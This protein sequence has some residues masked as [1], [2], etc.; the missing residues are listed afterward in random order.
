MPHVQN[1]G[2]ERYY[3]TNFEK[4]RGGGDSYLLE[5]FEKRRRGGI[6]TFQKISV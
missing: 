6:F 2:L 4:R 1:G 5:N 3:N